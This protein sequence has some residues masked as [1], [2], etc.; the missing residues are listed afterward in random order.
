MERM[1][2]YLNEERSGTV[3]CQKCGNS[4]HV[5][6]SNEKIP[7]TVTAKCSCGCAYLIHFEKRKHYR[8]TVKILAKYTIN[9]EMSGNSLM[10]VTDI[11]QGGLGAMK[12]GGEMLRPNQNIRVSFQLDDKQVNCVASVC[13]VSKER[14]GAKFLSMDEHSR[15]TLGFFL[16]P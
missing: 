9:G 1:R 6:F 11:S 2:V 8:K 14:F 4:K 3:V 7:V 13:H 10:Q 12:K 16:M 15:R 5:Q